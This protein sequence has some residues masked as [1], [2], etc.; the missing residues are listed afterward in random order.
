MSRSMKGVF[1][2]RTLCHTDVEVDFFCHWINSIHWFTYICSINCLVIIWISICF[3]TAFPRLEERL[4]LKWSSVS[5]FEDESTSRNV[6]CHSNKKEESISVCVIWVNQRLPSNVFILY[7]FMTIFYGYTF[8]F[9]SFVCILFSCTQGFMCFMCSFHSVSFMPFAAALDFFSTSSWSSEFCYLVYTEQNGEKKELRVFVFLTEILYISL[10][11]R[12]IALDTQRTLKREREREKQNDD[13]LSRNV[14][15]F[16]FLEKTHR[17]YGR[18]MYYKRRR[19][20]GVPNTDHGWPSMHEERKRCRRRC[21]CSFLPIDKHREKRI[22][23][24]ESHSLFRLLASVSS[25]TL[26]V[27][28]RLQQRKEK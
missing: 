21:S 28:S 19:K 27:L 9:H 3:Y 24:R 1:N 2:S 16:S 11:A 12:M 13:Q 20:K 15:I 10:S 8:L 5:V 23:P 25:E 22:F 6:S 4:S 26:A 17:S 7:V 18:R 14:V